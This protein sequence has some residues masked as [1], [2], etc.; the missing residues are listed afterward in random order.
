MILIKIENLT[1]KYKEKVLLEKLNFTFSPGIYWLKGANGQGKS[2]FFDIVAGLDN[3][4]TGKVKVDRDKML[5]L[6]N[7]PIGL[8]PFTVSEN[9]SILFKTFDLHLSLAQEEILN[10]FLENSLS[11]PYGVLSTGQ[12]MKLGFSLVLLADWN[13]VLL[14]ETF[15]TIDIKSRDIL[16]DRLNYLVSQKG[17]IVIYVS[18]GEVSPKLTKISKIISIKNKRF[19]YERE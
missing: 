12:K 9:L 16:V 3:N 11:D 4:I 13:I 2:T 14:D 8:L 7:H 6:T 10:V 19:V 5:Y 18:H 15:S 17:T 1:K